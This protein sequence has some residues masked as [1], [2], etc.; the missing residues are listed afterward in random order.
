MAT[1]ADV[2]EVD[3]LRRRLRLNLLVTLV[4]DLVAYVSAFV[5]PL[6]FDD[7]HVAALPPRLRPGRPGRLSLP[8]AY[9][10]GALTSDHRRK[11]AHPAGL[12]TDLLLIAKRRV[13]RVG[14]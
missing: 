11:R 9:R 5:S 4:I 10:A 3:H 13:S 6:L 2:R 1:T 14:D 7:L 8:T 12:Q